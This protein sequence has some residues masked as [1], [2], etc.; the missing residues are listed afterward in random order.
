MEKNTTILRDLKGLVNILNDGKQG[1][2]YAA[3]TTES[4]MLRPVFTKYAAQRSTY[5]E[6]L[7]AHIELHGGSADNE[8][9]GLLGALHRTWIDIKQAIS[10][11][12]Y[13]A[14]LTAIETGEKAAIEKFDSCIADYTDHAD[15]LDLLKNQRNG[16]SEALV[17]I[18]R[19]RSVMEDKEV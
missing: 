13:V 16:I 15:H 4:E 19:F 1:Y 6:E 3:E 5:A 14:V 8:D 12:E 17:D 9:G 11:Q 18:E 7:R 2:Q 10:S